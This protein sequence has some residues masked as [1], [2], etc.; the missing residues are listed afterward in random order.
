MSVQ[1]QIEEYHRPRDPVQ[2]VEILSRYGG[3]ARVI[4]GGTDILP[5]R[6]GVKQIDNINHLVDIADL[7]LNYIK[8][9]DD[10]IRIGAA[11]NIATIGASTLFLS[12]PYRALSEA[13]NSHS[14]TT[15]RNQATIG[16]NLCSASP[17]ADL[18]LPLLVMDAVLV[19]SGPDGRR[20]IPIESFFKGANYT[21]LNTDELLLEIRIPRCSPNGATAFLKLRRQQTAIDM[22]VVNVA[23]MLFADKGRCKVARIALGAVGPISLRAKHAE[24]LL[25]GAALGQEIIQKAA[26]TAAQQVRPI[27]DVRAT[28]AYRKEMVRVMVRRSLENSMRRCG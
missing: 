14:T 9:D 10:H 8:S 4:A 5:L 1:C 12:D 13:A 17:C 25:K 11:T 6:P 21:A 18:A 26:V 3:K 15:I 22:A 20:E 16:G 23:S 28:A 24:S 2:A 19:A 7:N 27:S